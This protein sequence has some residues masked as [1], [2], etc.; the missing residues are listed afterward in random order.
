MP[1]IQLSAGTFA[2]TQFL[3]TIHECGI[4]V[5]CLPRGLLEIYIVVSIY[6]A[7][8]HCERVLCALKANP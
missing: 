6:L 7:S 4:T 1:R 8:L 3:F 5:E 2:A